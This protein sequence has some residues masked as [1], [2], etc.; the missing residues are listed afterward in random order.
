VLFDGNRRQAL[1]F[2]QTGELP[3]DRRREICSFQTCP[4]LCF[5]LEIADCFLGLGDYCAICGTRP[6][7]G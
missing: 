7:R 4:L 6:R 1:S 2:L 3:R 5:V